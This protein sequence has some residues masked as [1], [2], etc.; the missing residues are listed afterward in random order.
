MNLRLC[1]GLLVPGFALLTACENGSREAG[2]GPVGSIRSALSAADLHDVAAVRY[3][4]VG[5]DQSCA[6]A[7]VA[8]TT[9]GLEEEALTGSV[10]PAGAGSNHAFSDALFVLATGD[11]RV[12]AAPLTSAC[13]ARR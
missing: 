3:T 6:D 9:V 8:G 11:Y 2:D 13:E 4:V 7:P 1:G 5:A 12:C 10:Q